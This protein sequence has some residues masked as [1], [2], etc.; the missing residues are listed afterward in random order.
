MRRIVVWLKVAKN[1]ALPPLML[2]LVV[3]IWDRVTDNW[4]LSK[5]YFCNFFLTF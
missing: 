1:E 4:D 3:L 5:F 2:N